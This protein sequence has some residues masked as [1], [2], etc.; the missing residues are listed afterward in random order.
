MNDWNYYI[1]HLHQRMNEQDQIIHSLE[2]RL[3][4]LENEKNQQSQQT[5]EKVE[6][7]FDQ[8][9]IEN[10]DGTLH[11]GLS[12]NDLQDIEDF[13][14]PDAGKSPLNQQLS[15]ELN[16]YLNHHGEE[17]IRDIAAQ[18]QIPPEN[19]DPVVLTE[20]IAKQLPERI[21]FYEKEARNKQP[22]FNEEQ[23]K[24]HITEQIKREIHH[25][26]NKYMEGNEQHHEYGGS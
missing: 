11:I 10:L 15:S 9:K 17:L 5:I 12:P 25:S 22:D 18:H 16:T 20:D 7:N 24:S 2:S 1:Y 21:A 8:L 14:V 19:F 23:L 13:S 6:Y 26:L 4:R 3:E